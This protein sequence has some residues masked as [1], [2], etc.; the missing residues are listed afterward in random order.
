MPPQHGHRLTDLL[1]QGGLVEIPDSYTLIPL[2]QPTRLAQLIREFA[3]PLSGEIAHP[4][5]TGGHQ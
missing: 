2:D 3:N 4:I 5:D 1:P